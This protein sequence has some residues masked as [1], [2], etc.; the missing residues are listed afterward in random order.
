MVSC[1]GMQQSMQVGTS[2]TYSSSN[3]ACLA[4]CEAVGCHRFSGEVVEF[5][6]V[7]KHRI[8]YNDGDEDWYDL[9]TEKVRVHAPSKHT[10]ACDDKLR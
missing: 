6:G 5:D 1:N 7:D 8:V 2:E 4:L 3:F 9:S 10:A